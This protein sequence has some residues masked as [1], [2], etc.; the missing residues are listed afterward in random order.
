MKK[1]QVLIP[2]V[3]VRGKGDELQESGLGVTGEGK[4]TWNSA[5]GRK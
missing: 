5:G 1:A 2:W 3:R 4:D